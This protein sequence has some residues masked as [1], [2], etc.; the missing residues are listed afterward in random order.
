MG[1]NES[2]QSASLASSS[3]SVKAY[4]DILIKQKKELYKDPPALPPPQPRV[5]QKRAGEM[6]RAADGTLRCEEFPDFRPNRT[7]AQILKAGS[8][9]GTYFR[10]IESAVTQ[11]SYG[12]EVLDEFPKE[13]FKGLK[14]SQLRS[15]TYRPEL[16][17]WGVKCGG[18]LGMGESSGWIAEIDPYGWFQWYCRFYLGR[19]SDDD[20]RQIGRWKSGTYSDC[21]ALSGVVSET[22]CAQVMDPRVVSDL[23][24]SP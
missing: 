24:C 3:S 22:W 5:H 18:S 17:K 7:P 9:G 23:S 20:E 6:R 19:R 1:A 10:P 4:R 14:Q 15:K 8:F 2:I 12:P 11:Q 21:E 16:N 13:W